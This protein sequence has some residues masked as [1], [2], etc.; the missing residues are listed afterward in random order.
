MYT[1]LK[2]FLDREI[3]ITTLDIHYEESFNLKKLF[4][5]LAMTTFA[6]TFYSITTDF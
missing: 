3:R 2:F 4:A 5:I 6:L 1:D